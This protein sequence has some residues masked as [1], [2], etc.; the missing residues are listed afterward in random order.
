[1]SL[2]RC[3]FLGTL[4]ASSA[5]NIFFLSNVE[6]D[7]SVVFLLLNNIDMVS[8]IPDQNVQLVVSWF[9]QC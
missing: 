8:K 4:F 7:V 5:D 6:I 3:T 1:M 2:T 9:C